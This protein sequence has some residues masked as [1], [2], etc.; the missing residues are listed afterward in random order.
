LTDALP[1]FAVTGPLA[2]D[3]NAESLPLARLFE[4]VPVAA[5]TAVRTRP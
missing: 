1:G 3:A 4:P 5:L 2:P